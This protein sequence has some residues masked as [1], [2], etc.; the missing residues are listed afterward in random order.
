M[1]FLEW[2]CMNFY[3]NFPEVC[4][5]GSNWQYDSIGSDFIWTNDGLIYWHI[6][7]LLRFLDEL[8][9]C[10][11]DAICPHRIRSIITQVMACFLM[12][13][14]LNQCWLISNVW[15]HSTVQLRILAEDL[16]RPNWSVNNIKNG[17]LKLHLNLPGNN[18]L[19]SG[20]FPQQK[21]NKIKSP[22]HNALRGQMTCLVQS[23][24][25]HFVLQHQEPTR[26]HTVGCLVSKSHAAECDSS[27]FSM[28]KIQ[29]QTIFECAWIQF[30]FWK[31][32]FRVP[33]TLLTTGRAWFQ[34]Q[35]FVQQQY[36]M[37]TISTL[38]PIS[39]VLSRMDKINLSIVSWFVLGK[40]PEASA[41]RLQISTFKTRHMPRCDVSFWYTFVQINVF[42]ISHFNEEWVWENVM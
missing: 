40:V 38:V 21:S 26:R 39:F 7:V 42:I 20:N 8:T 16:K 41:G 34:N 22:A 25:I 27:N 28:A 19:I 2:K 32:W 23:L 24:I 33:L 35:I 10:G 12:P 36:T 37:H 5:W 17:I 31:Q 13:P 30:L 29:M 18:E 1:H 14:Y 11:L 3:Y 6:H 15:L 4:Y 9:Y